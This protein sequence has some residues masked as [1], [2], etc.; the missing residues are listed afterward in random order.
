MATPKT[1]MPISPEAQE[2][3]KVFL[4]SAIDLYATS[5]N[6]RDQMVQRDLAYQGTN[7][8]TEEQL[9]ARQANTRGDPKKIQN[10]V[11]PVVMPQVESRLAELQDTFL[12]GS[13]IFASV[14]PPGSEAEMKQMD[15][16]IEENSIY[17]AWPNNLLQT[18]RD[19]LKY[20]L[21]GV[22]VI[23]ETKKIFN[24]GTPAN[25]NISQGSPEES[26]YSGN[27][28]KHLN[29]YNLILDTRVSPEK[30]HEMGEF[31]G[32]TELIGRIE[33]K[34]R[35][36][37]LDPIGSMN[38]RDAF[39]SPG[40]STDP[41]TDQN[42][43]FFLPSINPDALLPITSR[44]Q[45]NWLQW[46][47]ADVQ[48]KGA[49]IKYGSNYEWTVFYAR[50]LPRDFDLKVPARNHVQIWK[51]IVINRSVVVFAE[52]QTNAHNLLPI[53]VCKPSNDGLEWQSKSFAETAM[54]FQ[55]I[56]SALVNSGLDS[57][58]RKVYDR[59]LY[60]PTKV[61]VKDINNVSSVARIPVK[62]SNYG[63]G[64]SDAVYQIPYRDEGVAD[65]LSF[66]QQIV[67]M[68]DIA[69]GQ[70]R[71]QQGQF[72]KGNKTRKEFD[73]VMY[74]ASNRP[75]MMA[76]GLEFT[77]FQP[78]KQ[79]IKSNIL[80]Y[81]PPT[82]ITSA[83]SGDT[84]TIDPQAL[85]KANLK[86]K[87]AD[88][89]L[90]SDKLVDLDTMNMLFQAAPALPQI[91]VEYDLMGILAYSMQ[92]RGAGWISDFKRDEAGQ[93]KYL[94]TMQQAAQAAGNRPNQQPAPSQA[95]PR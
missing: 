31:A 74:N 57:Q 63:K 42:A 17:G 94:Q 52:R 13:P 10:I 3:V 45:T 40:P 89:F 86:M 81:Q 75:R 92:I 16:V 15:T 43:P 37:S 46:V 34:K 62:N 35:F 26:Y 68:G 91:T 76:L 53:I 84:V 38:F 30:N 90:S 93:Q 14:G 78:I 7:D 22:E 87:I 41:A 32:Y 79:I 88:G 72:Q 20:D 64:L 54:P 80:Q 58:R 59:L 6:V 29:S 27:F 50:I 82:S 12:T 69:N 9:R 51:F 2:K 55:A 60:D 61:A 71:V 49:G 1:P 48:E 85:R 66:S 67:Q 8:W 19:G 18:M 83:S 44:T 11:V 23:W 47:G 56:A 36:E 77:F 28:I 73:T 4:N 25:D 21:G 70:N 33:L 24:I 5:Y 65:I 95:Q 39:E